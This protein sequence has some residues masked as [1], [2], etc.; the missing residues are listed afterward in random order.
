MKHVIDAFAQAVQEHVLSEELKERLPQLQAAVEV[1]QTV[2]ITD[3]RKKL[4]TETSPQERAELRRRIRFGT[5]ALNYIDHQS[6]IVRDILT[7]LEDELQPTAP[8]SLEPSAEEVADLFAHAPAQTMEDFVAD[9]EA[10]IAS[11]QFVP[12]GEEPAA[13]APDWREGFD[14]EAFDAMYAPDK[15]KRAGARP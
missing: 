6:K 15:R 11:G 8:N 3:A 12:P 13:N 9:V 4:E 1:I 5:D 2:N 14:R 7:Q 10:A